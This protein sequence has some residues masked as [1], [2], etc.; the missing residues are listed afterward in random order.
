MAREYTVQELIDELSF[1]N[2][3]AKITLLCSY[4]DGFGNTGGSFI[5]IFQEKGILGD[6]V[7]LE[8]DEG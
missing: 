3:D 6:E 4:D 5:D 8:C 2:P 1:Y 7:Y